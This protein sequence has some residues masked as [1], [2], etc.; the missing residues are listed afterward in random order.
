MGR[1]DLELQAQDDWWLSTPI[2]AE[3]PALADKKRAAAEEDL[4]RSRQ[5]M[6]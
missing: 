4:R 2:H 6:R 3:P 5:R 1:K